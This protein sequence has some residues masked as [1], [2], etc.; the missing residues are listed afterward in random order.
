MW[1]ALSKDAPPNWP[2]VPCETG[3]PGWTCTLAAPPDAV[4]SAASACLSGQWDGPEWLAVR[5]GW[6]L[7][8]GPGPS[9]R[10]TIG[11]R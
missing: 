9:G 3:A 10:A 6:A 11:A 8:V 2:S 1:A 5:S 7:V 4:V